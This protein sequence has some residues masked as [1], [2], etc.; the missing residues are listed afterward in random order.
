MQETVLAA[1]FW[2]E[3]ATFA[4]S[5][6]VFQRTKRWQGAQGNRLQVSIIVGARQAWWAGIA[7]RKILIDGVRVDL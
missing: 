3:V 5:S 7:V 2:I 4:G 1:P 6:R